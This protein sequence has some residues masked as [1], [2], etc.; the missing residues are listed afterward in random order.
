METSENILGEIPA[1]IAYD[2]SVKLHPVRAKTLS[3]ING[4][5]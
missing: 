5:Y 4:L 2:F 3:G 1:L